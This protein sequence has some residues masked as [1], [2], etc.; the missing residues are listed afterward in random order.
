LSRVFNFG[1]NR[2]PACQIRQLAGFRTPEALFCP[3]I[4]RT[5]ESAV[6]AD[7]FAK[8][9]Q[10]GE[11]FGLLWQAKRDTAFVRPKLSLV[12]PSH[13]SPKAVLKPP[14]S[15]RFAMV[16]CGRSAAVSQTSRSHRARS[17][18]FSPDIS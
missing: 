11:A 12:R 6:A 14:Q 9:I 16:C 15:K 7:A 3:F 4:S 13:A 2:L 17:K 8:R 5:S 1:W 10:S 18:D